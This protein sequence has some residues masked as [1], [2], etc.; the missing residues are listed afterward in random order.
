M[1]SLSFFVGLHNILD[2]A[3]EHGL[4]VFVPSTIGAF[5][6]SSPK[7]PTPDLCAQRPRTI[8]GV[9]KVHAELMGEVRHTFLYFF[10]TPLIHLTC[11]G[12]LFIL[13]LVF[14]SPPHPPS[15]STTTTGMGWT[16]AV[17]GIQ[18]SSQLTPSPEEEPQVS[19]PHVL[20]ETSLAAQQ[21]SLQH[22]CTETY[23]SLPFF[24]PLSRLRRPN[25]SRSCE[26]R[27]L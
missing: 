25:L 24:S 26:E 21:P 2:I 19:R 16:S 23:D 27:S 11:S 22:L 8:Y 18:A 15:I 4:R 14:L 12:A 10:S 5:G 13:F 1:L 9:S 3:M 7:D 17:S 6:P 20:L